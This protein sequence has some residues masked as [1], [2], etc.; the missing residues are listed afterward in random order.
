VADSS[1]PGLFNPLLPARVFA[2]I[3]AVAAPAFLLAAIGVGLSA[4][5]IE[6]TVLA[7][8]QSGTLALTDPSA[9]DITLYGVSAAGARPA[10]AKC[11]LMTSLRSN[12]IPVY[13][14]RGRTRDV[15][16]RT[17]Y[18]LGEIVKGWVSGDTVT[19]EDVVELVAVTDGRG[20]RLGM[21]GLF[22][23]TGAG[24]ALMALIGFRS[25]RGVERRAAA[26]GR[27]PGAS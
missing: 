7:R 26:S 19:C 1:R 8:A 11:E 27:P 5:P 25:R 18:R 12:V 13:S 21:A 22:A 9:E 14:T 10:R 16:G 2:P 15:E 4:V 23:A 6:S 20:P 17:F 24:A 3:F